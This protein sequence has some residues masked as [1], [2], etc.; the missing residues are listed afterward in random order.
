MSRRPAAPKNKP[1]SKPAAP[2]KK[3]TTKPDNS[4]EAHVASKPA[5]EL[6]HLTSLWADLQLVEMSL[7]YR[8]QIPK[9]LKSIFTRRALW[10]Q[11]VIAYGRCFTSG[12]RPQVPAGLVD[13]LSPSARAIHE[14]ALI[15]RNKHVAHRVESSFESVEA[16]LVYRPDEAEPRA[17]RVRATVSAGPDDPKLATQLGQIAKGIKD[18]LWVEYIGPLE[19]QLL[20]HHRNDSAARAKA[21]SVPD[22]TSG[23]RYTLTI[24]PT[25]RGAPGAWQ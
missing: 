21:Q 14:A 11:A 13:Q 5:Q 4:V 10:E 17:I 12:R 22:R 19:I 1:A 2:K 20:D 23:D 15:W 3:P 24:N 25:Y 8:S 6:A 16:F 18:R 9:S 7:H